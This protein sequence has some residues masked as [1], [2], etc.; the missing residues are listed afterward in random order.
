MRIN[1]YE[2]L[3]LGA[4]LID[5]KAI[6]R[7]APYLMDDR[8]AS[9]EHRAIYGA[10]LDVSSSGKLVDVATVSTRLASNLTMI[11]GT[12]YL[13]HLTQFVSEVGVISTQNI[14]AWANTVDKAGRLRQTMLVAQEYSNQDLERLMNDVEDAD[15]FLAEMISK[16]KVVGTGFK[17]KGYE[18]LSAAVDEWEMRLEQA[19]QGKPTDT[20]GTGFAN[21]DSMLAGGL[22][23]GGVVVLAGRT[24]EGKTSL[25]AQI[26][27]N[28][29]QRLYDTNMDG[30]VLMNSLEQSSWAILQR[31]VLSRLLIDSS[32]IKSGK[33]TKDSEDAI[34][35]LK[36]NQRMRALPFLI[37]DN[38]YE[39]SASIQY[40]VSLVAMERRPRLI[41]IDFAEMVRDENPNES[42]E[43]RVA[44]I[45]LNAKALAK[46]TGAT[47]LILSQYNR[48]LDATLDKLGS[49][50]FLRYSG[51]IEHVADC[52]LHIYN[53]VQI[54]L[55]HQTFTPPKEFP[56]EWLETGRSG[57]A[58]ILCDKHRDGP[59]GSCRLIWTPKYTA[60]LDAPVI[61]VPIPL[62]GED[63]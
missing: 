60:F 29:A 9:D 45:F 37:N 43:R 3:V 7:L 52:I 30:V 46:D 19:F 44:K 6:K 1:E 48:Q 50:S 15:A 18:P 12:E 55:K 47:V 25:A 62:E 4:C 35:I 42:E 51:T 8:F 54:S 31:I 28:V 27:S 33:L 26:G 24:S 58:Y 56:L 38:S 11:G 17:K 13:T 59:V 32:D 40:G 21:I 53:P 49:Y 39:T 23:R 20:L 14:E 5:H 10:M 2:K 34:R 36:E 61:G 57:Y 63:F 22:P 41:I 16:L